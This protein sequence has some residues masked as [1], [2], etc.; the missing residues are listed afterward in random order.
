MKIP[1]KSMMRQRR[2][3][4]SPHTQP[5]KMEQNIMGV[6]G[7]KRLSITPRVIFAGDSQLSK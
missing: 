5:K 6:T 4:K 3:L 1:Y 2:I 7:A